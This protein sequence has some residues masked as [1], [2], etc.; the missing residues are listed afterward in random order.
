MEYPAPRDRLPVGFSPTA[1][2]MITVSGLFPVRVDTFTG[3]K[4]PKRRMR[5]TAALSARGLKGSPSTAR[6]CRRMTL[7][8]V[9]VFPDTLM[10]SIKIRLPRS[11]TKVTSSVRVVSLRFKRG[12]TRKKSTPSITAKRSKRAIS[13]STANGE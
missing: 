10:R 6:N 5:S 4:N 7:S 13:S 2:S 3:S 11:K 12:V 1:R 9:D 8:K